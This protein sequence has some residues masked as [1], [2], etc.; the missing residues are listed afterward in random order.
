MRNR[1][2]SSLLQQI[3]IGVGQ[4]TQ[5]NRVLPGYSLDASIPVR[6]GVGQAIFKRDKPSD[7]TRGFAL[8]APGASWGT[9]YN[10][11]TLS[12]LDTRYAPTYV[13]YTVLPFA[14]NW[15]VLDTQLWHDVISFESGVIRVNGAPM[16]LLQ[17]IG[18][19]PAGTIPWLLPAVGIGLQ[20]YGSAAL[21]ATEKRLFAIGRSD[22]RALAISTPTV[23]LPPSA[24]RAAGKAMTIGPRASGNTAWLGQ[25]YFTG[26]TWDDDYGAW[27]FSDAEVQMMLSSP[28]LSMISSAPSVD[29]P[30]ATLPTTSQNSSGNINT[31][32]TLPETAIGLIG[33]G[34]VETVANVY[35]KNSAS[36]VWPNRSTYNSPLSGYTYASYNRSTFASSKSQSIS[37]ASKS[38]SYSSTNSRRF[39]IRNEST[40]I[41]S[42]YI[43]TGATANSPGGGG[44]YFLDH[45]NNTLKWTYGNTPSSISGARGVDRIDVQL[46]G[47]TGSNVTRNVESQTMTAS[48]DM[49][50]EQLV[51]VIASD[52]LSSGPYPTFTADNSYYAVYLNKPISTTRV[53]S[54][55]GL[56]NYVDLKEG[57]YLGYYKNPAGG[58][59]GMPSGAV[60]EIQSAFN[61]MQNA[62]VG[63]ICYSYEGQSGYY[64]PNKY[65]VTINAS[66]TSG[67]SYLSWKTNDYLFYDVDNGVKISVEGTISGSQTYGS[68]ASVVL[69]VILRVKTRYHDVTK[70]LSVINFTY[71]NLFKK[72]LIGSTGKYAVPSPK[73]RAMF[74]PLYQEQG[75]FKGAAYVTQAEE[76][77]GSLP[78]HLFRFRLYLRMYGDFGSVNNDNDGDNVYYVPVN[79]LE[80]LYAICF[81]QDMGVGEHRYPVTAQDRFESVQNALFSAPFSV[82]VRDGSIGDWDTALSGSTNNRLYRV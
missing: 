47:I 61:A 2:L 50:G 38:M 22:V 11:Y 75:S 81:S 68:A 24:P 44:E 70:T 39:D 6:S 14:S 16:S 62:Y 40:V 58:W 41:N 18:A 15:H 53:N 63:T 51:S 69:T 9:R 12:A 71:S 42:Q 49:S 13:Q 52:D 48:I 27:A 60:A 20:K 57:S 73:I 46:S 29:M 65:T 8:S 56:S 17:T 25:L 1:D 30:T 76:S 34:E 26:Q 7:P 19:P 43:Y 82:N 66:Q 77:S 35:A 37:Q 78:A 74:A 33:I 67:S 23:I 5:Q 64:H 28:Y 55:M 21:N 3:D 31:P 45:E 32:I 10:P 36:V 79:M 59:S 4:T 80:M 54:G 72:T